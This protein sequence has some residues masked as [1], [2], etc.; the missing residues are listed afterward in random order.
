M[1]GGCVRIVGCPRKDFGQGDIDIDKS[2][3]IHRSS[4]F[5]ATVHVCV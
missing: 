3:P 4:L 1:T 5:P 2:S